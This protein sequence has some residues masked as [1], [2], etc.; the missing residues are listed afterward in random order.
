[1]GFCHQFRWLIPFEIVAARSCPPPARFDCMENIMIR[2]LLA[3]SVVVAVLTPAVVVHADTVYFTSKT[4]G[5]LYSFDTSGTAITQIAANNTFT[6]PTALAL[7]P[8]G[9]LY[10]GDGVGG[11]RVARYVMTTGSVAT[12]VSLAGSGPASPGALAFRTSAQGGQMLVGR[13]PETAFFSYPTG[14]VLEVSGWNTGQTPSVQAYTTGASVDYSPGLAVAADGTL[15]VSNS[16]YNIATLAMTGNVLKFDSSGTLQAEV[17]ADGS[18]SGGL[19]GPAGLAIVGNSLF[20][21][22]TMDG[23]I[24]KTNLLDPSIATNTTFFA[25]TPLDPASNYPDFIGPLAAMSDGGLLTGGVASSGLI[26]HFDATGSLQHVFG[27][28]SYGAVGG[29]VAVPEPS[30]AL[31]ALAGVSCAGLWRSWRR[32]A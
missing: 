25:M 18:G 5:G 1:M 8:D 4:T 31:L 9:N 23:S 3:L 24:Y 27:D 29:I 28:A 2:R 21:A 6:S 26:Y 7:G 11:G 30:A 13:N 19:F 15:Y 12:V 17:T 10:I 14:P 32:K 22:S 16:L 20:V